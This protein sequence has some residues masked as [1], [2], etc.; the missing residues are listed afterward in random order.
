MASTATTRNRFEK[1]GL[2]ENFQ[3]W[4]QPKLNNLFDLIDAAIDGVLPLA[5]T[6]SVTLTANNFAADQARYRVIAM[7]GLLTNDAVV[8]I[9]AVQ[10]WYWLI[11]AATG[12]TVTVKTASGVGAVIPAY[13]AVGVY[14]DG[15]DC[16]IMRTLDFA[17]ER[18][19]NVGTGTAATDAV[20]K[21]QL[22]AAIAGAAIP[23]AASTVRIT[24]SDTTPDY[25]GNKIAVTGDLVATVLSPGGDETLQISR[26]TPAQT[27]AASW[28]LAAA[29]AGTVFTLSGSFTLAMTAS[30]TLGAG[31]TA[32]FRKIDDGKVTLDPSGAETIDGSATLDVYRGDIFEL[33]CTGAG[34]QMVGGRT[35]VALIN[36]M[37]LAQ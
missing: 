7:T 13:G 28:T 15:L 37:A 32:T 14:C 12:G 25:V 22:D 35:P 17:G 9:P 11:N 3:T 1:Q 8:T 33:R 21:G 36:A 26:S 6:G 29:D 4:G 5:L 31:W 23:G 34:F 16:A 2:G 10:K 18:L 30:A 24:S 19:R 27:K 20:N